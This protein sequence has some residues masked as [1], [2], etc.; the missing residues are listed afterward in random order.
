ML[1]EVHSENTHVPYPQKIFEVGEVVIENKESGSPET[2]SFLGT[3]IA[4][5]NVN[6]AN[7]A[8]MLEALMNTIGQDYSLKETKHPWFLDGRCA[9][10]VIDGK[11]C[12]IIGEIHPAVITNW[13][14]QVPVVAMEIDLT[15]VPKLKM[16][17]YKTFQ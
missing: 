9:S 6:Y 11:S 17:P 16:T 8:E 7:M 4:G 12:G 3:T 13:N 14:L 2:R 5:A 15:L 10:I 1:L